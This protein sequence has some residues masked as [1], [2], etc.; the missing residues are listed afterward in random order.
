LD[1]PYFID[2]VGGEIKLRTRYRHI[3]ST[4]P[5]WTPKQSQQT[6]KML[7]KKELGTPETPHEKMPKIKGRYNSKN[8]IM[9]GPA[10]V[11][12]LPSLEEP[13]LRFTVLSSFKQCL[14]IQG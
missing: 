8:V 1:V 5:S 10:I 3:A 14:V 12:A 13:E 6:L 11:H 2:G 4:S 9:Q 7:K